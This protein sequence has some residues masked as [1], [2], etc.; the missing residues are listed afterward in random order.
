MNK[1][2]KNSKINPLLVVGAIA[3]AAAI[4]ATAKKMKDN[5]E[6]KESFIRFN[7]NFEEFKEKQV[8]FIGG[9]LSSLAGAAYLIRDCNFKGENIHIIESK[10][11]IEQNTLGNNE[12]GFINPRDIVLNKENCKNFWELFNDIPSINM[13]EMSVT[14]E[15]FNF[16]KIHPTYAKA[17]LIDQFGNK[18]DVKTM[19]FKNADRIAL[20]KLMMIPEDK[21]EDLTIEDWFRETPNFFNTNFWYMWQT[22]FAFEKWSSL[23]EFK[24]YMERI[25][26]EISHIDT[27]EESINSTFNKYE[28]IIIPL[29][30]YLLSKDVDFSINAEV[31]DIDFNQSE[32]ITATAIY[33]LDEEGEKVIK[34]N[35]GDLCFMSN[36]SSEDN[37][38]LG[39]LNNAPEFK[40]E[41]PKTL[42][43]WE[44][45]AKKKIGLGNPGTF[46][47]NADNSSYEK[48]TITCKGNK[49]I[50]LIEQFS[51]NISGSGGIMTFRDSNWLISIEVP[52]QPYFKNQLMDTTIITGYGLYIDRVG[53]FINK[54]MKDCTG[55]EILIELLHHLHLEENIDEVL[56]TVVNV[57]P[58]MMPYGNA[59]LQP[60]K[61]TDRPKVI[62]E[63]STNFAMISEFVEVPGEMVFTGEY[64]VRAAKIAVYNLLGVKH[65]E[66][67][68]VKSYKKD[69]KVIMKAIKKI[70]S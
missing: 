48:F 37:I 20:I 55:K 26:F 2:Q 24:R 46:F 1:K 29:R 12:N 19:G 28:S 4:A 59:H 62:P 18:I 64:L 8:Y 15:I 51:G 21:I 13:P 22:T 9:G 44:K 69:M 65:K 70:Y 49:L 17:R 6:K 39:D 41:K 16:D 10:N 30:K 68:P 33:I 52:T 66:I 36:G 42:G 56:E 60:R 27:L 47:D 3:G 53:N 35:E 11:S 63:G 67:I 43:I 58:C 5:K 45:V 34:L 38:T 40:V 57:I 54:K 23:Y 61:V 32:E 7:E 31:I 25:V 14:E 50:K